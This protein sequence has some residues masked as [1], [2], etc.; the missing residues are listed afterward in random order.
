M[1]NMAWFCETRIKKERATLIVGIFMVNKIHT[2]QAGM[3]RAVAADP[4]ESVVRT[5][6]HTFALSLP[7]LLFLRTVLWG[8]FSKEELLVKRQA[9]CSIIG[10]RSAAVIDIYQKI[11]CCLLRRCKRQQRIFLIYMYIIIFHH[12]TCESTCDTLLSSADNQGWLCNITNGCCRQ[13]V[14]VSRD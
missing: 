13:L 11:L 7:G 2:K 9:M 5:L 10:E 12:T 3:F 8:F 14:K 4:A 1:L 6:W